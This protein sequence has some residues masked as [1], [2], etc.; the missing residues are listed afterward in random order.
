MS[1]QERTGSKNYGWTTNRNIYDPLTSESLNLL[2]IPQKDKLSRL[3]KNCVK[4]RKL[5]DTPHT[6]TKKISF[7]E[8][9]K[10]KL[11]TNHIVN[12]PNVLDILNIGDTGGRGP[13]AKNQMYETLWDILI[14]FGLCPQLE[15]VKVRK[16]IIFQVKSKMRI[17][18]VVKLVEVIKTRVPQK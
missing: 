12:K 6:P 4:A 2:T 10:W 16:P 15:N 9:T 3:N 14:K 5:L 17:L 8:T 13:L 18:V 11:I 7:R 1:D